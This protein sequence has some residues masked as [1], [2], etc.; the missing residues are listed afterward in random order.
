MFDI[1]RSEWQRYRWWVLAYALAHLLVLV[2]FN[3]ITDLGQQ[4]LN[5]HRV[6]AGCYA[7]T[8]VLLGLHQMGTWR[9]PNQWLNLLHRPIAPR[10][11]GTALLMAG[12]AGLILAVA[13]PIVL[14]VAWQ[15]WGTTRVID[16][17][18]GLLPFSALLVAVCGYAVGAYGMLANRR[19]A[20]S[21]LV[22]LFWMGTAQASGWDAIGVQMLV[23][24][25]GIALVLVAFRPD[26]G[27][28]PRG[29]ASTLLVALPVQ[30]GIYIGILLLAFL[31]EL[32]WIML[33]THPA[34]MATPPH[35]GF[36][37]TER[38]A[39]RER[40]L[41]GLA[42]ATFDDAPLWREQVALSDVHLLGRQ[43][44]ELPVREAMSN[45]TIAEFN[46]D[47]ARIRWTF[48]HASMRYEGRNI[49]DECVGTLGV[50]DDGRA[51]PAVATVAD[52]LPGM[53]RGDKTIIAGNVL[54]RYVSS[55]RRI[56]PRIALPDGEYLL[57]VTPVGGSLM[58]LGDKAVYVFDGRHLADGDDLLTARQRIA[59]PGLPGNLTRAELVEMVDGYL[60]SFT[61][62][63]H[64]S[65]MQGVPPYQTVLRV[66]D[67]GKVTP[68]GTRTMGADYPPLHR[69]RG[70][71]PSPAMHA[72]R[73]VAMH[74]FA[75]SDPLSRTD[76]PPIPDT[77]RALA[78][79]LMLASLVA[80]AWLVRRRRM[81]MAVG[82]AWTVAC[83]AVGLPAVVS[84]ALIVPV[85]ER[86]TADVPATA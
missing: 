43:V 85:G 39:P 10:H 60:L 82:V 37:E 46:D 70:W 44:G 16:P 53:G 14:T 78:A 52:A 12:G 30:M 34:N 38:M 66:N 25:S 35:G 69:Y 36:T 41:A 74:L 71:W 62:A 84:L 1:A 5:V 86:E 59:M 21:A 13:L 63:W 80:G 11:I 9:R 8:G 47:D 61:F 19:Y 73:D 54:Y 75:G 48:S 42:G 31:T 4:S 79:A 29:F 27:A 2:F 81:P 3:R 57:G 45:D 32:L 56:V 64:A 65:D 6:F 72:L 17:R 22:L 7:L 83:G 51:F 18:H 26:L 20:A 50:G 67:A 24:A 33:G 77:M 40:V 55:V 68:V 23:C 58:V 49:A 28:P 15:A 76:A